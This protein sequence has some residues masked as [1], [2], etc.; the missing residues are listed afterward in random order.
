MSD[1]AFDLAEQR[2]G[3]RVWSIHD[4]RGHTIARVLRDHVDLN[5]V[6]FEGVAVTDDNSDLFYVDTGKLATGERPCGSC[7]LVADEGY[8]PDPCIGMIPGVRAACCGH[9]DPSQA[10]IWWASGATSRGDACIR[11]FRRRVLGEEG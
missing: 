4:R 9:G 8:V 7:G 5:A 2:W 1:R 6:V 3:V 10:Y 11:E